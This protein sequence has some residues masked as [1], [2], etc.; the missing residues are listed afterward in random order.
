MYLN[1]LEGK[2]FFRLFWRLIFQILR[3]K[4]N[5]VIYKLKKNL[6]KKL[7]FKRRLVNRCKNTDANITAS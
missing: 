4:S 6:F 7:A 5:I 3:G 1:N 2:R